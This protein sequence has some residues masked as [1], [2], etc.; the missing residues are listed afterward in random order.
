[1]E[2][3]TCQDAPFPTIT[4]CC[5]QGCTCFEQTVSTWS[6][7]LSVPCN[8]TPPDGGDRLVVGTCGTNGQC[9]PAD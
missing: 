5:Q 7:F 4:V 2:C 6:E 3:G 9:A 8:A 1:M